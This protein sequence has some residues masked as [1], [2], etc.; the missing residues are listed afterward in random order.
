MTAS[1][2]SEDPTLLTRV[3]KPLLDDFQYWFGRSLKVLEQGS[4]N[5][6]DGDQQAILI[7]RLHT[8][9]AETRTA[10]SLLEVTHGQVGVDTTQVMHWH[11]LATEC[12]AVARRHR[13]GSSSVPES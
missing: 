10:A 12:W 9:L 7:D 4:L 2:P 5:H 6:L 11:A 3:L 8:A 1:S 13:A